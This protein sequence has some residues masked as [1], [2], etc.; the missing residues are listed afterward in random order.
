MHCDTAVLGKT[1]T[2]LNIE[3]RLPER[4]HKELVKL[5]SLLALLCL[6]LQDSLADTAFEMLSA[7]CKNKC[8]LHVWWPAFY[9]QK[10]GSQAQSYKVQVQLPRRQCG[11]MCTLCPWQSTLNRHS[12]HHAIMMP[13]QN[14]P[15]VYVTAV[16]MSMTLMHLPRLW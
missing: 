14:N 7:F 12:R 16:M 4:H 9:L 3:F 1:R 10:Y 2:N 13:W 15:L 5:E 11:Q 6:L 8:A